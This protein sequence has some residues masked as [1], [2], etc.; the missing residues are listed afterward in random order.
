MKF[1]CVSCDDSMELAETRGPENGSLSVIFRCRTC[2]REI[3]MLTNPME[4]QMVRSLGVKVGGAEV[5]PEPAETIRSGLSSSGVAPGEA[6]GDGGGKCP[7]TAEVASAFAKPES[8][9]I[10]WTSEAEERISRIPFFV[11]SMAKKSVE[12]FAQEN[13]YK[14]ITVE[15]M[16]EVRGNF[17]M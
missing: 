10:V 5:P 16:N 12:Q 14:E 1:L 3:A 11:R 6:G 4:T 17:G 8:T 7:F 2:S 15:V 13:G 9:T